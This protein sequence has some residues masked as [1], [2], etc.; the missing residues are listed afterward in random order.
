VSGHIRVERELCCDDVAVSVNGDVLTYARALAQLESY[1]PAHL[2]PS[3]AANGGSLSA[4]IARLLGQPR[5]AVPAGVGSGIL[6]AAILLVAGTYGLMFGRSNARP[7]FSI[8]VDQTKYFE[9][10]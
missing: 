7:A 1:R 5:P 3:V 4:R 9:L 6:A 2:G 8:S 10:E